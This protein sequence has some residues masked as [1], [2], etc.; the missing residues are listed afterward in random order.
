[1]PFAA[2]DR[3]TVRGER[4]IVEEATAFAV[5][6]VLSLTRADEQGTGRRCRLLTPYDR[7]QATPPPAKNQMNH[8]WG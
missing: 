2:G 3:V 6:T 5:A 8:P 4:W 7:P 1:M